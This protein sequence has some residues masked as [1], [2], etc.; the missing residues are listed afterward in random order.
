MNEYGRRQV[1]ITLYCWIENMTTVCNR[2]RDEDN[3][4]HL[5]F[6]DMEPR[7]TGTDALGETEHGLSGCW[8]M[9]A[10]THAKDLPLGREIGMGT[11]KREFG[12]G[13]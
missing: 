6:A 9:G 2:V 10:S 11:P 4:E 1:S 3:T 13:Q 5:E 12:T 7:P 8:E